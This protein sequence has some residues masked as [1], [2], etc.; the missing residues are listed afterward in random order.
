MRY[1]SCKLDFII[2]YKFK[3]HKTALLQNQN[4]HVDYPYIKGNGL[5]TNRQCERYTAPA[6]S[7]SENI[8]Y[9]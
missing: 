6:F 4:W 9:F 5:V 7:I 2:I 3:N 1:L 8:G